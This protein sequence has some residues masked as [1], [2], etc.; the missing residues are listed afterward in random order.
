[1]LRK[2][3]KLIVLV[4]LGLFIIMFAVANRQVVTVSLDVFGTEPPLFSVTAPLFIVVLLT[5]TAGVIVGGVATWLNQ[6]KWRGDARRARAE[7]RRLAAEVRE[8]RE[9]EAKP[10]LPMIGHDRAH[11][12]PAA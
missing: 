6:A 2:F 9:R 1:M 8:A 7:A 4:P 12:R 11:R 3:L 10:G 5:L